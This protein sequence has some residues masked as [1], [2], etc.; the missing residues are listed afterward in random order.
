MPSF[1]D[2]MRER[3]EYMHRILSTRDNA[4]SVTVKNMAALGRPLPESLAAA[5]LTL[6]NV[7]APITQACRLWNL[8]QVDFEAIASQ[9]S[10]NNDKIPGWGSAF[11]GED[12]PDPVLGQFDEFFPPSMLQKRDDMSSFVREL[13]AKS[14]HPNA[15]LYTAMFAD[16]L[17]LTPERAPSLAVRG[18][19]D[20]W[21]W[22]WEYNY[23]SSVQ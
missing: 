14:L 17:A 23:N 18:R 16:T 1:E 3:A 5:L 22:I 11:Y 12:E 8:P 2:S 4:S 20:S 10:Y 21:V 13:T 15:A 19:M 9:M 7:H 6:G